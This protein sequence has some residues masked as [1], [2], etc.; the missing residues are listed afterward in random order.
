MAACKTV[1][2]KVLA[3]GCKSKAKLKLNIYILYFKSI[4]RTILRGKK[5]PKKYL[6]KQ[7]HK[8]KKKANGF[9]QLFAI[10]LFIASSSLEK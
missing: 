5:N 1:L 10:Y 8:I 7:F 2:Y 3:P 6:T 4:L 9:F